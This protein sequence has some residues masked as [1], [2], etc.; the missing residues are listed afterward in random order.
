MAHRS[1]LASWH[2]NLPY[3]WLF[4]HRVDVLVLYM[5][6]WRIQL[7]ASSPGILSSQDWVLSSI[8]PNPGS[9]IEETVPHITFEM[10]Q[11]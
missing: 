4:A 6:A 7:A 9:Y 11:I 10:Y 2:S 3:H 1:L 8:Q 5:Q